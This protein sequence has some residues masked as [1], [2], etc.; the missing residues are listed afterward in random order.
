MSPVEFG[1]KCG[2]WRFEH[3]A[4]VIAV[5]IGAHAR[6]AGHS[7]F[8]V[9]DRR[10]TRVC[11]ARGPQRQ[12]LLAQRAGAL[13]W[14]AAEMPRKEP[15]VIEEKCVALARERFAVAFYCCT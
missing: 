12:P 1:P 5:D 7:L 15:R 11:V 2:S 9:Y 10:G 4:L 13:L 3:R 8:V 6:R 14:L